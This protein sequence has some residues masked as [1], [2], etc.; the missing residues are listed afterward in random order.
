M[1]ISKI[2]GINLMKNPR[3]QNVEKNWCVLS[4]AIFKSTQV[5]LKPRKLLTYK[6]ATHGLVGSKLANLLPLNSHCD[7]FAICWLAMRFATRWHATPKLLCKCKINQSSIEKQEHIPFARLVFE[8]NEEGICNSQFYTQLFIL[9]NSTH[10]YCKQNLQ[11]TQNHYHQ[12]TKSVLASLD[13]KLKLWRRAVKKTQCR[14]HMLFCIVELVWMPKYLAQNFQ[15]KVCKQTLYKA[16]KCILSQL[17][18]SI[19]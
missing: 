7:K 3:I 4:N 11:L 15:N 14:T 16:K 19:F 18:Y 2:S 13:Y 17:S 5:D 1:K 6:F 10:T 12:T 9:H 8:S